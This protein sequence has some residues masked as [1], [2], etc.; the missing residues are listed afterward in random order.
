MVRCIVVGNEKGGSGKTTT[1]MHLIVSLLKKGY[2]VGSIDLD[3]RQ[4]SLTRYIENRR[5]MSKTLNGLQC[6]EHILFKRSEEANIK[7]AESEDEGLLKKCIDGFKLYDFVVIDSPGSDV[8]VSRVAHGLADTIITPIND[9]FFDVDLLGNFSVNNPEKVKPGVYSAMVW[10]QKLKRAANTEKEI[11]WF[12]MQNRISVLDTI[13]NRKIS[14]GLKILSNK[15]G[16]KIIRGFSDRVIFKELFLHGLTLH[17]AALA[18]EIIK[19]TPSTI[20]AKQELKE[21]IEVVI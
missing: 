19:F 5:L 2:K 16:F 12:V 9:S 17:D 21:F 1:S 20:A 7:E 11:N 18:S 10:E 8:F 4:K 15:V 3:S 13:N 14:A 6:P